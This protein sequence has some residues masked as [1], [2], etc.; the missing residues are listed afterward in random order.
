M[1]IYHYWHLNNGCTRSF[2]DTNT[3]VRTDT[4]QTQENILI[5]LQFQRPSQTVPAL[6]IMF[7]KMTNNM[8]EPVLLTLHT[9]FKIKH[10]VSKAQ[11]ET[12]T[13]HLGYLDN[14]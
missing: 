5:F 7:E 9:L 6:L 2:I 8:W 11:G 3:T 4:T 1:H 14:F 12:S 10:L 13:V